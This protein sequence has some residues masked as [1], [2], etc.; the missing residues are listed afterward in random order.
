MTVYSIVCQAVFGQLYVLGLASQ[1]L[2]K[3]IHNSQQELAINTPSQWDSAPIM[4]HAA[5]L[6]IQARSALALFFFPPMQPSHGSYK[7]PG[8]G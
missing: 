1:P 4:A 5:V 6:Q 2:K 3:Y 7:C 8:T